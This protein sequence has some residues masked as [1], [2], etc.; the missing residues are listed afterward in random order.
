M[1]RLKKTTALDG[2]VPASTPAAKTELIRA[3]H[4]SVVLHSPP[5]AIYDEAE[6]IA[7][8]TGGFYLDHF[9]HAPSATTDP[10]WPL[11]HNLIEAVDTAT[12]AS[13]DNGGRR[14][15]VGSDRSRTPRL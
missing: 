15:G 8:T 2:V 5:A 14:T 9:A 1:K 3:E 10:D 13:P 11:A 12:G 7:E 6:R 4:A